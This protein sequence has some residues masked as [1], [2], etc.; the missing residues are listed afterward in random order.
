MTSMGCRQQASTTPPME[1]YVFF[2]KGRERERENEEG[3][4]EEE[5]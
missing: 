3:G 4:K 2:W 1:P 5:N